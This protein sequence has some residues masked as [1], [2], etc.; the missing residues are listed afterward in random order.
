MVGI[1][2]KRLVTNAT[3]IVSSA[4]IK[5][6]TC[7]SYISCNMPSGVITVFTVPPTAKTAKQQRAGGGGRC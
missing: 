1:E 4:A 2:T 7:N 3:I 6:D 5:S